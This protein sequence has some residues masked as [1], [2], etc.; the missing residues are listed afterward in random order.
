[1]KTSKLLSLLAIVAMY[2][3]TSCL[4]TGEDSQKTKSTLG[5]LF[6]AIV[7]NTTGEIT[8]YSNASFQ[9]EW[10][11]TKNV[12]NI[13]AM[14]IQLP[15]STILPQIQIDNVP[16][17]SASNGWINASVT[18]YSPLNYAGAIIFNNFTMKVGQSSFS[19]SYL[20][21]NQ[22]QVYAF[23]QLFGVQ[24]NTR[25]TNVNTGEVY[26]Y[27]AESGLLYYISY[28]TATKNG[29]IVIQNAKFKESD[30]TSNI[31]LPL[32]PFNIVPVGTSGTIHMAA[33]E[34]QPATIASNLDST[35]INSSGTPIHNATATNVVADFDPNY[36]MT[37]R[38]DYIID[39]GTL[40][41]EKYHVD[42]EANYNSTSGS[43]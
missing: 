40:G 25:I 5:N 11:Y 41:S 16:I 8:L 33:A 42:F 15:N 10:D 12:A 27:N 13:T 31:K 2:T 23:P 28:D 6:N 19:I 35:T 14:G 37:I 29:F 3:L 24:G 4:G 7:D 43:L 21:N 22:Y 9:V 39:N 30:P 17:K 18:D 1:M 36:G 32:L 34:T 26:N 20:I 38:Y